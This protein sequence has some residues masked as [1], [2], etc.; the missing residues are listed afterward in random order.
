[1]VTLQHDRARSEFVRPE[2]TTS[3]S[4]ERLIVDDFHSVEDDCDMAIDQG[5]IEMV[6]L[7]G[8]FGGIGGRSN[9]TVDGSHAVRVGFFPVPIRDLN[10]I[11]A[12]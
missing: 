5:D 6:P 3:N 1:M 4:E 7:S 11:N 9:P 2:G 12:A 8:G 10:F